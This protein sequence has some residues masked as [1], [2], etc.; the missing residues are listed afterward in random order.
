ME[1]N[2][3]REFRVEDDEFTISNMPEYDDWECAL[4]GGGFEFGIVWRPTK[5]CVPNRF[6]RLMQFLVFGNR[7]RKIKK[8]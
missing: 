7:W 3:D 1:N 6:W 2:G 4:L 8:G 5:G